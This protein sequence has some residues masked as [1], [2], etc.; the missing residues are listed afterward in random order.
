MEYIGKRSVSSFLR[1]SLNIIW[2]M[3]IIVSILFI[4]FSIV[5]IFIGPPEYIKTPTF[6]IDNDIIR[7]EFSSA[8]VKDP[9]AMFLSF[10][11]L[12][13][14]MLGLGMGIVFQ[15]QKIFKTLAAG[16]PFILENAKR[17]KKISLFIFS[18]VF[19]QFI[20][21]SVMERLIVSNVK[22]EGVVFSVKQSVNI[23]GILIGLMILVLAEIFR[24]GTL[25]KE[26]QDLTI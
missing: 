20:T 1:I 15:I 23:G 9:K 16:N 22:V 13:A 17:L 3:G 4:L 10:L 21:G 24:Q 5:F 7:V 6:S 8:I 25:L 12:G 26:E 14:V 2:W 18:G 19:F 11:P